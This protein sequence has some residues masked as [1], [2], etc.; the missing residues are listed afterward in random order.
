[1]KRSGNSIS[2]KSM[3]NLRRAISLLILVATLNLSLLSSPAV[4]ASPGPAVA[5]ATG[6]IRVAGTVTVDG[7]PA[8]SGQTIF[9]GSHIATSEKSESILHL[10][11]FTRLHLSQNT[12]FTVDFSSSSISSSL[13]QGA[14]HAFIA[15]GLTVNLKTTGAELIT[16]PNQSSAF[17]IQV[18]G[19]IT[20][21]SVQAGRVRVRVG[22]QL[23]SVG[24][25]EVFGTLSSS[26]APAAGQNNLT[27]GERVGIFAA[28]GIAAVVLAIA[29]VGQDEKEPEFG[30]CVIVP[31]GTT[32]QNG[33]CP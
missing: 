10:G 32:G 2:S 30:G 4:F 7:A 9:P 22:D 13:S 3:L 33:I 17:M 28:I 6:M 29:L 18:D 12:E 1:M 26:P 20:K 27:T 5:V 25:G 23:H 24:A 16:D 14:M 21:V 11:K 15:A 31:S 19:E 8:T